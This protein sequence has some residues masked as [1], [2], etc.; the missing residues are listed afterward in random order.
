MAT[1]NTRTYTI[2]LRKDINKTSM[3]RRAKRAVTT[4]KSF[5]ERHMK[6]DTVKIGKAL[7]EA[8]WKNG[9]QNPPHKVTVQC[10]RKDDHVRV[11]LEGT[12]WTEAIKAQP[13]TEKGASLKDKLQTALKGS[14][15]ESAAGEEKAK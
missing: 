6:T 10:E 5:V 4:V 1:H 8:L 11:E 14:K 13:K 15:E 2:P 12:A 9:M 3:H 7:N